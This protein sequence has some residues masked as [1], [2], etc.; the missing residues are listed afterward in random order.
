[1]GNEN[2]WFCWIRWTVGV[3]MGEAKKLGPSSENEE[4][5]G[6]EEEGLLSNSES[7]AFPFMGESDEHEESYHR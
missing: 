2:G 5:S 7:S 1:M 6:L 3:R 4:S